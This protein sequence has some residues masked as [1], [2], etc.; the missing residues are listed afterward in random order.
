MNIKKI[1][2]I[3]G[4][5]FILGFIIVIHEFGHFATCQLFN[6]DTPT[7]SIGFGPALF[8]KK[9]NGTTFQI[10]LLPL[11]G[12]VSMDMED[13]EKAPYW[14]KMV[15]IFAGIF[16][17]FLLALIILFI[18]FLINRT[19]LKPTIKT[20]APDSPAQ[21]VG[22]KTGDRIIRVNNVLIENDIEKFFKKVQQNPEKTISFVI[23]RSGTIEEFDIELD[24]HTL[25]GE[26]IGYL[27]I[28]LNQNY[29]HQESF[30]S[31]LYHAWKTFIA[32]IRRSFYFLTTLLKPKQNSSIVSISG[33]VS[34]YALQHGLN[35]IL[36]F[37]AAINIE[38]GLFNIMPIPLLD[39]G[40]AL[41]YT[42]DAGLG[43]L[44]KEHKEMII[45]FVYLL[46]FIVFILILNR[47]VPKSKIQKS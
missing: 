25:F 38:L 31:S 20:V 27:G 33:S 19:N 32:M 30:F 41:Y 4:F 21:K 7:F 12:Y 45:H 5:I 16:N 43:T 44:F 29:A 34:P 28:T 47:R 46:L 2:Y 23:D 15:I 11:G 8:E 10:A 42:L 39:G 37:I 9:L 22:L 35:F 1:A 18:L 40:Q 24:V 17:N 6:I 26:K 14:Q 13:L 36:F 3:V